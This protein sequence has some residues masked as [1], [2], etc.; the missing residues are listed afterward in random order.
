MD[1][2]GSLFGSTAPSATT[3]YAAGGMGSMG[4]MVHTHF[5]AIGYRPALGTYVYLDPTL[6]V[7]GYYD[8]AS[9]CEGI[10]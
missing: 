1:R 2:F 3:G 6:V 4:G 7:N 9:A 8:E 5:E 10:A